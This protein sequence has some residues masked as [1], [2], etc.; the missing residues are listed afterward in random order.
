MQYLQFKITGVDGSA[1]LFYRRNV[2]KELVEVVH[3]GCRPIKMQ[4]GTAKYKLLSRVIVLLRS[5]GD[6]EQHGG[7]LEGICSICMTHI[8]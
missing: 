5:C 2:L 4:H 7:E 3:D 8:P 1:S 6:K